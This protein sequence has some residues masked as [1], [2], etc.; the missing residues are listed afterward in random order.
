MVEF[1]L[2]P[3]KICKKFLQYVMDCIHCIKDKWYTEQDS[4]SR[5]VDPAS[6]YLQRFP[7][8]MQ[9]VCSFELM[10]YT[11]PFYWIQPAQVAFICE[12]Y[13]RS[14][15]QQLPCFA[16]NLPDNPRPL[17]GRRARPWLIQ[18]EGVGGGGYNLK[19]VNCVVYRYPWHYTHKLTWLKS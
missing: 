6:K 1:L 10:M 12:V 15:S 2:S 18:M 17:I 5:E 19:L 4:G 3:G 14:T 11:S 13:L 16:Y 8:R 9:F 7:N